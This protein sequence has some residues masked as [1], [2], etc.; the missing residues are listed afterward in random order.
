MADSIDNI[1]NPNNIDDKDCFEIIVRSPEGK[2]EVYKTNIAF[3]ICDTGERIEST[4]LCRNGFLMDI[5]GLVRV[6]QGAILE[7]IPE[8]HRKMYEAFVSF[9]QEREEREADDDE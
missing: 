8:K 4:Q 5:F 9:A 2:E 6:G 7:M 3:L 1:N